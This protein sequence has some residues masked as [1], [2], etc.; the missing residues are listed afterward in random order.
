MRLQVAFSALLMRLAVVSAT[1]DDFTTCDKQKDCISL[2]ITDAN[3]GKECAGEAC[4]WKVCISYDSSTCQYK[5]GSV[6]HFCDSGDKD[7]F[8]PNAG[9]NFWDGD[10]TAGF[11]TLDD[12]VYAPKDDNVYFLIKDGGGCADS[13]TETLDTTG[14]ALSLIH[15]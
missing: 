11:T 7:T 9:T 6:S 4:L 12:C 15:I 10:E 5:S 2:T 14:H 13:S 1:G 8:C 3:D